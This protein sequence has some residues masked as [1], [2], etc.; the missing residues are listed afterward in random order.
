MQ[1]AESQGEFI[2]FF[3]FALCLRPISRSS[4]KL[5]LGRGGLG[6]SIRAEFVFGSLGPPRIDYACLLSHPPSSLPRPKLES[7]PTS[8][9]VYRRVPVASPIPR[10]Y[11]TFLSCALCASSTLAPPH[12]CTLCLSP[13]C[14]RSAQGHAIIPSRLVSRFCH[15]ILKPLPKKRMHN[16]D[17]NTITTCTRTYNHLL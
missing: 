2:L 1:G 16:N 13:S 6:E 12:L 17:K 15:T 10:C 9:H 3:L 4:Y 8:R 7:L 5:G 11:R 14:H